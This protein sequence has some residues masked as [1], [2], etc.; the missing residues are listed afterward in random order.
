MD[1]KD[2][3]EK[4]YRDKKPDELSWF[5]PEPARSIEWIGSVAE[6]RDAGIVDIGGGASVLVDRLLALGYKNISV[7]DI[8]GAALGVA[9]RRLGPA[10]E[11]VRFIEADVT[12][13]TQDLACDLWHDRAVFHFL[14]EAEDRNCYV[15]LLRRSIRPGGHVIL[16]TF[17]PDGPEKC[18]GL[19]VRRYD[20][21][22]VL[23]ELGSG[24]QLLREEAEAHRTPADKE[25]RFRYFLLQ[26]LPVRS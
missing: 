15:D 16:A 25:Q 17:A 11:R 18:S 23:E 9:R 7:L 3:W 5:Q 10:A 12:R 24:F 8:S 21:R 22:L 2:H 13:C 1:H 20:S 6:S 4:I 14:T 26:R 19:P